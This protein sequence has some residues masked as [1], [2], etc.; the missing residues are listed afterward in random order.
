MVGIVRGCRMHWTVD[1][2]IHFAPKNFIER[3]FKSVL[4]CAF[5][6]AGW[7]KDNSQLTHR[8]TGS[9]VGC[10]LALC[11]LLKIDSKRRFRIIIEFSGSY[12]PETDFGPTWKYFFWQEAY[13]YQNVHFWIS[14][15]SIFNVGRALRVGVDCSAAPAPVSSPVQDSAGRGPRAEQIAGST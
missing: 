10:F 15:P 11:Q 9:Q 13:F 6:L 1:M 14:F 7:S 2:L 3:I 8:W 4:T 5:P 12:P